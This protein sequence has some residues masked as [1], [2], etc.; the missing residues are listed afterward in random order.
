[1]VANRPFRELIFGV[2]IG[3]LGDASP[4][5]HHGAVWDRVAAGLGVVNV[6]CR[7]FEILPRK[8]TLNSDAR[9]KLTFHVAS[10]FAN[11]C[12]NT[13]QLSD[14]PRESVGLNPL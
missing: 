9:E 11:L 12:C 1:M 14:M 3:R 6:N 4:I 8:T 10:T 13:A 5:P 2:V 7:R